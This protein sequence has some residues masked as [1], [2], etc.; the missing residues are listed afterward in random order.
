MNTKLMAGALVALLAGCATY[1]PPI[2]QPRNVPAAMAGDIM[3][4]VANLPTA[5]GPL[6]GAMAPHIGT[7]GQI[8]T[9]SNP[10]WVGQS[11]VE[12][13]ILNGIYCAG[14]SPALAGAILARRWWPVL[15]Q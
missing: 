13:Q 5:T 10:Y 15:G 12:T 3:Q 8:L 14:G 2:A 7:V 11:V 9:S 1:P 6:G 4:S